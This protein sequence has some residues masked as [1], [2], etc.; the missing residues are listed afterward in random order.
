MASVIQ[1]HNTSLLK[2]I[3]PTDIKECSCYWKLKYPLYKKCLPEC[4]V[5]N[6]SV[7]TLD[8]NETKLYYGT[9]KKNFKDRYNNHTAYFRNKSK[10]KSTE[11]SKYIWELKNNKILHNLKWCTAPKARLYLCGSRKCNLCLTENLTVIKA[12]P[13]SLLNTRDE[14][15]SKKWCTAP[16]ARLYLCGSRKY[17][18][19]LTENLTVIKAD[20]ESLLNTRDELVSTC[21]HMD[22][23]TLKP[24]K[25]I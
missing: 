16:K 7:D 9:C 1:S 18:L 23:F 2:D 12:D 15:V 8:T 4:L 20:P 6:N 24:F 17:N 14:L 19:C 22:K 10:E 3:V 5:H 11:F 13:E 21:K 25:E